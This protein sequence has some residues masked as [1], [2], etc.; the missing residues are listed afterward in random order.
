MIKLLEENRINALRHQICN[1]VLA[2]M[3]RIKR[4]NGQIGL[5]ENKKKVYV[6]RHYPQCKKV[7]H[8]MG[9]NICKSV[10]C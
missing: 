10:I 1:N 4:K 6:E 2:M 7:G 5:H 3:P 8:R 9:D